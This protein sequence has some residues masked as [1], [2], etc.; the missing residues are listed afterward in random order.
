MELGIENKR[1]LVTG[2]SQGIGREISIAF[3]REGC[4]VSVISRNRKRLINLLDEMNDLSR[5]SKNNQKLH[6]YY[7]IDLMLP[8]APTEAIKELTYNNNFDIVIHN[9]G[10]TLNVKDPLAASHEWEK[11]WRFNVGIAIEMNKMLI[12]AMQKKKWGRIIH[13]SS[14]SAESVRGSSPYAAAKAYLNAYVKGIGRSFA[15]E[16]IIITALMPGAV[17]AEGGHWDEK[18]KI[19]ANNKEAFF[20]KRADFLRHHHAIGRLGNAEEIAPFAL[21]MASD[22][23]TFAAASI[24]PVDGGTM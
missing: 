20:K 18:S 16:G 21:F 11:V 7:P 14:I 17:Y 9:L 13:I 15:K 3:A 22:L 4:K 12:P 24:I 2:A 23:V 19:N 1:V 10:G 5:G 6:S 8:G